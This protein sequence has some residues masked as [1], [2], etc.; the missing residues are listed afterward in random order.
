MIDLRD[1]V[2]GLLD[3]SSLDGVKVLSVIMHMIYIVNQ[4]LIGLLFSFLSLLLLM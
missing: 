3:D 2:T 1:K 4:N